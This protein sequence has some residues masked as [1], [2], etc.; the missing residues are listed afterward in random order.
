MS[1][2]EF[3]WFWLAHRPM[4]DWAVFMH[5]LQV[6]LTGGNPYAGIEFANPIWTLA[7]LSPFALIPADW[8]PLAILL[9][10]LILAALLCRRFQLRG[11]GLVLVM[12]SPVVW[13]SIGYGNIDALALSGLLL[14]A[15]IGLVI[16]AIKPQATAPLMLITL[17]KVYDDGGLKRAVLSAAPVTMLGLAWLGI[18][19]LHFSNTNFGGNA[20]LFPYSLI[21]GL[22][23]LILAV[24]VRS[25]R[26]ALLA[27]P[28]LSPY[29]SLSSFLGPA[30]VLPGLAWVYGAVKFASAFHN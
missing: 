15:P 29:A 22:P 3:A 30:L 11:P 20:S 28:C 14:P 24:K 16:L 8:Q 17:L 19:G 13:W 4:I 9:V 18:Y 21:L 27:G 2:L 6:W 26:L 10:T 12:A 1:G 7:L 23:A 25:E 5:A